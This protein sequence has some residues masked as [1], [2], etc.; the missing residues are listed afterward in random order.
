MGGLASP[1]ALNPAQKLL[2]R[3][4]LICLEL[5]SGYNC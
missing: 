1:V 5:A 3:P 4:G 2:Q